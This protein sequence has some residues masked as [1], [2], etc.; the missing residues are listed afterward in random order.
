MEDLIKKIENVI[1]EMSLSLDVLEIVRKVKE[2]HRIAIEENKNLKDEV[3]EKED[4]IRNIIL[5]LKL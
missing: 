5:Q 2:E 4:L 1:V 3:I